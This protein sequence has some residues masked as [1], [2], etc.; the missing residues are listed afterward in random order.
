MGIETKRVD[1]P[2]PVTTMRREAGGIAET[3]TV[4]N[5][6]S[7]TPEET[8][9]VRKEDG[10][11]VTI[12][13]DEVVVADPFEKDIRYYRRGRGAGELRFVANARVQQTPSDGTLSSH[14]DQPLAEKDRIIVQGALELYARAKSSPEGFRESD[15][16]EHQPA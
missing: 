1:D 12:H 13:G 9:Q 4:S 15:P 6:V 10:T 5:N 7:G 11:S 16:F 3:L 8:Y 2:F 14:V